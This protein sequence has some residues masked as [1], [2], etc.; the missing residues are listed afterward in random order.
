[1]LEVKNLTLYSLNK[2][3]KNYLL[4]DICFSLN[5][6]DS[7]GIISKSGEGKSTL[8]KALLQIYDHNVMLESGTIEIDNQKFNPSYRGN[9]ISLLPQHPNSYLNPLMKVGRQIDEMLIYH[10]KENKKVAREKTIEMMNIVGIQNAQEVYNYYPC[11]LSGGMQQRV[12]LCIALIC[13]PKILILDEATSYLD[14]QTKESILVLIKSLKEKYNFTLIMISHDFKEIYYLCNKIAIMRK[15]QLIEFANANEIILNP[16]HPYTVEL[17][18]DYLR[19]YENTPLFTCP[20]L[21]IELQQVPPVIYVSNSHFVRS[22][23]LD[24]KAPKLDFPKNL[25]ELKEKI[26]EHIRN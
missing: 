15:G 11:E 23:Y 9:T 1:M 10:L 26:Y 18:L 21:E 20:L 4:K 3:V 13:K 2:N 19:Y 25:S 8:V 7:L 17:L 6:G 14:A 22:W 12:C 16:S 5:Q 24:S